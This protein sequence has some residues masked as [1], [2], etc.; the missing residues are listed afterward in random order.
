MNSLLISVNEF[1]FLNKTNKH[2]LD[3]DIENAVN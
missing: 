2:Y 1:I 3:I